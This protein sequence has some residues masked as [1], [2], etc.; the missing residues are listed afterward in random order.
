MASR[1]LLWPRWTTLA[2]VFAG[3]AGASYVFTSFNIEI[4]G[5]HP[6]RWYSMI[7]RSVDYIFTPLEQDYTAAMVHLLSKEG[8]LDLVDWATISTHLTRVGAPSYAANAYYQGYLVSG[9]QSSMM[10]NWMH[11]SYFEYEAALGPR[12]AAESAK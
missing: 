3:A 11:Q 10:R 8:P 2:K 6:N 7:D 5:L 4:L 9:G 1:G 12:D